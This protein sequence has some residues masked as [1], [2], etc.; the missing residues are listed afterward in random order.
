[1]LLS[2]ILPFDFELKVELGHALPGMVHCLLV[3]CHAYPVCGRGSV[4]W[5]PGKSLRGIIVDE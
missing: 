4:H 5:S 3:V 1:M 2:L